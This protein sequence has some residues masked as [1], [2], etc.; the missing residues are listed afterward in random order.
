MNY[1]ETVEFLF[2]Q[3][4]M[5]QRKGKSA[6]KASLDT[7]LALD[8]YLQQPHQHFKSIHIAGTNGKG[9]V[10]HLLAAVL[11]KAGYK[12]GLYTS[13]HLKDY[14]ERI[15]I[16][17]DFIPENEVI[18]FVEKHQEAINELRPSFFEMTV[19]MAFE[20][21]AQQQV[22]VAVI[23]TGMGGRLDST[24]IIEP[25][26]SVIT[27]IDYDH[28][29]F[30]GNTLNQI[31]G[32]KAGII[33]KGVPVIV[34]RIQPETQ[35]VFELVAEQKE[36]PLFFTQQKYAID[37]S[38]KS[39][40]EKQVFNVRKAENTVF[41]GLKT[42]LLGSYQKENVMVALHA[43]ELLQN[44]G[45][46]IS[47]EA[48]YTGFD[49]VVELTGLHGRWETLGY[50]PRIIADTAHNQAGIQQVVA[51]IAQTPYQKLHFVL[52]M[53][54]DKNI[55]A[56]LSLLP[57]KAD[58]YFTKANIPRAL[59]ETILTA[60]AGEAGLH[61]ETY[62]SVAEAFNAAKKNAAPNDLIFVGGSTFVVAEVL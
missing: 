3:L 61:G 11:Q 20:Y 1:K 9:S 17:G 5:Y 21:F 56:I 39:L 54:N 18:R 10:A 33:K 26:L 24:N 47:K 32:E 40:G 23:E 48:I 4:P 60:K 15:K 22:D 49:T 19:A 57:Q 41:P 35:T 6:Y 16:N 44:K 36:A 55:E 29:A 52:G 14:R 30:L 51:Q 58:Y 38:L 45:F 62:Y 12:T 59:D 8:S 27:N 50:N 31:A 28:T 13:P 37:Y 34:G 46:D 53:V 25:E 7:T 43:I 42:S 2:R